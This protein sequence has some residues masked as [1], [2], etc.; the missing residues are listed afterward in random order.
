[1]NPVRFELATARSGVECATVA[2]QVQRYEFGDYHG[3]Y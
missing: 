3:I 2:P 1:M